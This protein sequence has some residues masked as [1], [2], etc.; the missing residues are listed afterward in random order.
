LFLQKILSV[1]EADI[2]FFSILIFSPFSDFNFTFILTPYTVRF[3]LQIFK[4]F[5]ITFL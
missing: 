2:L 3:L 5:I 1:F 4:H